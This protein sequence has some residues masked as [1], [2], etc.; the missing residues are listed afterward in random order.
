M[1]IKSDERKATQLFNLKGHLVAT[2]KGTSSVNYLQQHG[3]KASDIKQYDNI[4]PA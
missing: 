3:F 4:N 2:Q 1:L